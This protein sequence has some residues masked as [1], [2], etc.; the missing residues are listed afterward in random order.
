MTRD[1]PFAQMS[2]IEAS[3]AVAFQKKKPLDLLAQKALAKCPIQI[4]NL[5][6]AC[7]REEPDER[8]SAEHICKSL[9]V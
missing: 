6:Q 3:T 2:A 7:F 9:S 4:H 5:M 8:P 1:V